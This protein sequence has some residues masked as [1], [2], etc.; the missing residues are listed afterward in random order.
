MFWNSVFL[1][2]WRSLIIFPLIIMLLVLVNDYPLTLS[3]TV[4]PFTLKYFST[5]ISEFSYTMFNIV[6][7]DALK[8]RVVCPSVNAVSMLLSVY[9]I[10]FE[11]LTI[12]V[13]DS[14][15]SVDLIILKSAF[16]IKFWGCIFANT[17]F[18]SIYK[19]SF[20]GDCGIIFAPYFDPLTIR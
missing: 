20:I 13:Y 2:L 11:H 4:Y 10:S 19:L 18:D 9:K 17:V 1:F 5:W 8:L 16:I 3:L 14:S 6:F 12:F 15:S 7:V